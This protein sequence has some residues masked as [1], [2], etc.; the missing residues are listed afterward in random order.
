MEFGVA[1]V[2]VSDLG[3]ARLLGTAGH[4]AMTGGIGTWRYMAPEV[5]REQHYDQKAG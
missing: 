1:E 5:V 4:Y 2:K 3:I